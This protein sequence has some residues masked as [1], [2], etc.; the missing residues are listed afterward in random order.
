MDL[1]VAFVIFVAFATI[2]ASSRGIRPFDPPD[3]AIIEL[4]VIDRKEPIGSYLG[5]Q[6]YKYV[7]LS[8]GITYEFVSVAVP[9]I[10]PDGVLVYHADLPGK[11]VKIDGDLL[12]RELQ[13]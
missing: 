3:Q 1:I 8:D 5:N 10:T 9:A 7:T 2:W 6:I 11:H 12:Y 4:D 13:G